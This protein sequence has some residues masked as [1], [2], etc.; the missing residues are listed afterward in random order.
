MGGED[1]TIVVSEPY[2]QSGNEMASFPRSLRNRPLAR[3]Y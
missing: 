2:S 1:S 3:A